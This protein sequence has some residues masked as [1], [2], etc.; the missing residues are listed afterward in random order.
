[1]SA[2]SSGDCPALAELSRW[3]RGLFV[4]RRSGAIEDTA[5]LLLGWE[6]NEF[7]VRMTDEEENKQV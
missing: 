6:H 7:H 5:R 4:I 3:K 1:M 2:A